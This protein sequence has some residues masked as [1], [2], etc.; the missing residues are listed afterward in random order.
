MRTHLIRGVLAIA[1]IFAVSGPALAQSIVR[2]KVLDGQ[3]KPIE[4]AVVTIAGTEGSTRK[5][6]VKTNKNGEFLQVGLPSGRYNVTATKDKL[7]AAAPA[8]VTEVLQQAAKGGVPA[9]VIGETG[10]NRLR[11]AVGGSIEVDVS[12]DEA[13]RVWSSAVGSLFARRVA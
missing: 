2:G 9:R 3:G 4:G 7:Q 10:G 13:E 8:N 11:I 1:V 6:E 12:L 5:A